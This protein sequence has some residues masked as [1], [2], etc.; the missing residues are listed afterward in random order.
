MDWQRSPLGNDGFEVPALGFGGAG[1][2]RI[3][4]SDPV[5][6]ATVVDALAAGIDFLD[7]SPLYGESERRIGM[8]LRGVPRSR[9]RLSSKVGTHPAKRGDYSRDATLWSIEN[10]LRLLG[11][12]YLD[13]ALVHD[14]IE[15]DSVFRTGGA[16]ET[17]E[18]LRDQGVIGSMGLGQRRHDF[19]RVA[20][21]C[22]RFDA[23]LTFN[24]FHPLRT[25]AL[26]SGL[27]DAATSA[28]VGVLNGSPLGLGLLVANPAAPDAADRHGW[29]TREWGLLP[30]FQHFCQ[31]RGVT[32]AAAGLQFSMRERRIQCTLTGPSNPEE[33]RR[34]LEAIA[35]PIPDS[36]W[37]E[38]EAA[39]F[40]R[41]QQ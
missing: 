15:L 13:L 23:I 21:D 20:I 34:N 32:P 26:T 35:E 31:H 41:G 17:L 4:I 25:T 8:A 37:T 33:L 36:F 28:G 11:T 39:S 9:Y 12:E 14:P 40:T 38:L 2:G 19:H 7:T 22:G 1:I 6:V 29:Q 18:E 3:D 27:L 24:D 30:Q 16:L 5:A 10:S